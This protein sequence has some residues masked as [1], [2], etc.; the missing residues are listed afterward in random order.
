MQLKDG[1][2]GEEV[3]MRPFADLWAKVVLLLEQNE[4]YNSVTIIPAFIFSMDAV[5]GMGD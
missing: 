4:R 3:R 2:G 5:T 1:K